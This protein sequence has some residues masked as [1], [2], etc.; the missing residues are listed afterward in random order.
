[1]LKIVVLASSLETANSRAPGSAES[2]RFVSSSTAPVSSCAW[3]HLLWMSLGFA[4]T[5][6]APTLPEPLDG[7][8]EKV[9][10]LTNRE[11]QTFDCVNSGMS[12][13]GS[14]RVSQ[15]TACSSRAFFSMLSLIRRPSRVP[16]AARALA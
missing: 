3:P 13:I 8:V 9:S 2:A 11:N 10:P 15:R 14:R 4:M 12:C 1:M 5:T 16:A 6:S 7:R